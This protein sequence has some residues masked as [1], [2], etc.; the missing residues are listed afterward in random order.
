MLGRQRL[1]KIKD[2]SDS[3]DQE[4]QKRLESLKQKAKTSLVGLYNFG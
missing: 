1:D 3:E 2:G 4:F